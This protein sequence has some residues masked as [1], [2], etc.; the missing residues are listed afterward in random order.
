MILPNIKA[1]VLQH[2]DQ[3]ILMLE[4]VFRLHCKRFSKMLSYYKLVF[5]NQ[6]FI[7]MFEQNIQSFD[8]SFAQSFDQLKDALFSCLY[9]NSKPLPTIRRI[10]PSSVQV[11]V[12]VL[13]T[14]L[15]TGAL[16]NK[17]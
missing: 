1:L 5:F 9:V 6:Y 17:C 10:I 16:N 11:I 3:V 15:P 12:I 4:H 2:F 14:F 7:Q 8:Q 13:S